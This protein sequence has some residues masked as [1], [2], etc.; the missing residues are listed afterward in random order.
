MGEVK[1]VCISEKKGTVKHDISSCRVITD[2]GLEGDA[3]AGSERQVSLLSYDKVMQFKEQLLKKCEA[4]GTKP[5]DIIP[6]VFGENILVA[7]TDPS[8][9][10]VGTKLCVGDVIL[11][12]TQ[13]GKK[14]HTGCEISMITGECIMPS[15]GVFARVLKGGKVRNGDRVNILTGIRAAVITASDRAYEGIRVDKSGPLIAKLLEDN[16]YEVIDKVLHRDSCINNIFHYDDC[17]VFNIHIEIF[18]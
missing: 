1:A 14:C 13:I 18:F 16:G 3:H 6:G 5:V 4:T 7:G 17:A 9:L 10:P 2:H 15:E 8:L 12:I 11:E